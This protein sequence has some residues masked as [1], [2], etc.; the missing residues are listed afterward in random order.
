MSCMA[1]VTCGHVVL[2]SGTPTAAV[3]HQPDIYNPVLPLVTHFFFPFCVLPPLFTLLLEGPRRRTESVVK[4]T[5]RADPTVTRVPYPSLRSSTRGLE[6]LNPKPSQSQN[7]TAEPSASYPLIDH[8]YSFPLLV[9][10]ISFLP[11]FN[12]ATQSRYSTS[13]VRST[14]FHP[15]YPHLWFH[16]ST[17]SIGV[18]RLPY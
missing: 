9:L 5:R 12:R 17:I 18:G 7:G 8:L 1:C 3:I 16:R 6:S 4:R 14:S 13:Y 11:G 15:G 2:H 10:S